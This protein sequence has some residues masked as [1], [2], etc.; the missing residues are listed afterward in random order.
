MIRLILPVTICITLPWGANADT[1]CENIPYSAENCVRT[2]ACVGD[3]GL[4][5]DGQARGWNEGAVTGQISDGVT[6]EGTWTSDGPMGAGI[7]EMTCEDGTDIRVLY[8]TQDNE[9][10]ALIGRGTDTRGRNIQVWSGTNVLAFLTKD[11]A[12]G[13]ALPCTS[14]PIP[15]S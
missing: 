6:C 14:G 15:M 12:V 5:F 11:G 9:T 10:G 13:P 4:Y 8:H 2:V 7:A 3:Q 1:T